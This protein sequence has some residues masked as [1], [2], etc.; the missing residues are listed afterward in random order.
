M[1]LDKYIIK[2]SQKSRVF[3]YFT[4]DSASNKSTTSKEKAKNVFVTNIWE[5]A[6]CHI[7]NEL[8]QEKI[9]GTSEQKDKLFD[10]LANSQ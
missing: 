1:K 4:S 5:G 6:I 7:F 3:Y 10:G 8:K 9:A 2:L